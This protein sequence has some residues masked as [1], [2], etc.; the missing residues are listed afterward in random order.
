M[1]S[2]PS[3]KKGGKRLQLSENYSLM[4]E[5][6]TELSKL[7]V[8]NSTIDT[9]LY[10]KYNVKRGLRD[11]DGKGVL[12]GLTEISEVLGRVTV[13]GVDTEI[14]GIL[15]YRGYDI[16]DLIKGFPKDSNF[17]FEE[18]VYLLLFGQLP[19]E[20]QFE[21]FKALFAGYRNLPT[22]FVRDI[23]MK[24]PSRDM[25]NTLARSVLTLYSYDDYASNTSVDNVL[26]QC[27]ELIALFPQLSV[28]GYQ[29]YKY[30]H[31]GFHQ[32]EDVRGIQPSVPYRYEGFLPDRC[33]SI[34]VEDQSVRE[35][36][37][38]IGSNAK[39]MATLNAKEQIADIVLSLI[40]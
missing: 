5:Q 39:K 8:E 22:H 14:D 9:S 29:T 38:E 7:V 28:Y 18:V 17:A 34:S 20:K 25:M 13:D 31:D 15:R 33:V 12:T 40:K 16:Q 11:L 4:T 21:E 27:I 23:I 6:I 2:F 35:K 36:L 30:Y 26:R 37:K 32:C 3:H 10:K 24:A 19:T 1:R